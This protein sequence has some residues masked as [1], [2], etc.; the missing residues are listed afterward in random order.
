[1]GDTTP[2]G[3]NGLDAERGLTE[4]AGRLADIAR[5]LQD[6]SSALISRTWR[7]EQALRQ[8]A[9]ALD[10]DLRRLHSAIDSAVKNGSLDPKNAEKV[11]TGIVILAPVVEIY[12]SFLRYG[13]VFH[14]FSFRWM[15]NCTG[16]DAY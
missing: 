10:S 5:E 14:F 9:L 13:Y 8:R 1:M 12:A 2:A 15:R 6:S 7:E 16:Q 11:A 4:E 3:E